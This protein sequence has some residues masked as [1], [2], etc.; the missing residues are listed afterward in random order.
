M[1]IYDAANL[2]NKAD[3]DALGRDEFRSGQTTKATARS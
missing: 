1:E 2:G 3:P